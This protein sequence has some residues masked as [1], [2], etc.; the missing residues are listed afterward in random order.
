MKTAH[1]MLCFGL[2]AALFV[3]ACAPADDT[4]IV[5]T[6]D[7][8][9]AYVQPTTVVQDTPD[10]NVYEDNNPDTVFVDD[11]PDSTTTNNNYYYGSDDTTDT[12][13]TGSTQ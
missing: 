4:T 5:D 11:N 3:V 7:D 8:E 9:G 1:L 12:T 10:V 6:D 2:I 13:V